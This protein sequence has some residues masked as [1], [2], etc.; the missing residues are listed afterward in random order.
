ME[1][2]KSSTR[3]VFETLRINFLSMFDLLS[4][5]EK[6]SEYIEKTTDVEIAKALSWEVLELIEELEK[7]ENEKAR[8]ELNDV[9]YMLW[10]LMIKMDQTW[11]LDWFETFWKDQKDK[12]VERS[13]HL[14]KCEKISLETEK[15]VWRIIKS[16]KK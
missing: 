2:V 12:I 4:R 13:P 16:Q 1:K 8:G 3:K 7:W 10:Q 6:Y 9:I 5:K 15:A 14:K 11:K